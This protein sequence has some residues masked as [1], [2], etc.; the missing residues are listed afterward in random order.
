ML[1]PLAALLLLLLT[2]AAAAIAWSTAGV[3]GP[4]HVQ[5]AKVTMTDVMRAHSFWTPNIVAANDGTII[6]T[7]MAKPTY[8][9]YMVSSRDASKTWQEHAQP[10]IPPGTS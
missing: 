4:P 9:N 2:L 6:V 3:G 7:A 1:P 8:T 5:I 10:N